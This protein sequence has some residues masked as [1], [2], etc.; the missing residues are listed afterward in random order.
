MV[1]NPKR[2]A[3]GEPHTKIHRF[4][5]PVLCLERLSGGSVQTKA[6]NGGISEREISIVFKS[7]IS[8]L[9]HVHSRGIVNRDL[10]AD[11]LVLKSVGDLSSVQ[12]V[13]F[14]SGGYLGNVE[15]FPSKN[16]SL[17]RRGYSRYSAPESMSAQRLEGLDE[18]G[19]F[20]YSAKTDLFQAGCA[21]YFLLTGDAYAFSTTSLRS[22]DRQVCLHCEFNQGEL[23]YAGKDVRELK[24]CSRQKQ[25]GSDFCA[26]CIARADETPIVWRAD[27]HINLQMKHHP[28]RKVSADN[29]AR[30]GRYFPLPDTVSPN[31]KDLI[32][33]I[34]EQTREHRITSEEILRHPFLEDPASNSD[35]DLTQSIPSYRSAV[36]DWQFRSQMKNS[37]YWAFESRDA[38]HMALQSSLDDA[39]VHHITREEFFELRSAFVAVSRRELDQ[40]PQ[41]PQPLQRQPSLMTRILRN[42]ISFEEFQSIMSAMGDRLSSLS[43]QFVFQQFDTD[44]NGS[45]NYIEFL[46][47]LAMVRDDYATLDRAQLYFEVLN[48]F[49]DANISEATMSRAL[50]EI[51]MNHAQCRDS[52]TTQRRAIEF[53]ISRVCTGESRVFSLEQFTSFY[54]ELQVLTDDAL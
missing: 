53:I 32:R 17:T 28:M 37:F 5:F 4:P 36:R 7:F 15:G 9:S 12:I 45:I 13:D 40:E 51:M 39:G 11:N 16:F 1:Y 34:L 26:E 20:E 23:V 22:C 30:A 38:Q 41:E 48:V 31:A 52:N 21:L 6:L 10:K 2:R 44:G 46:L 24:Q 18:R 47:G 54:K 14:G 29:H 50:A 25:S 3:N 8:A 49:G 27:M 43:T 33:R 42:G 35:N 19:M